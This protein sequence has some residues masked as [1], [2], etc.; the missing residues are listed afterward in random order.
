[1]SMTVAEW[2]AIGLAIFGVAVALATLA[3]NWLMWW[4]YSGTEARLHRV[5]AAQAA[6]LT[7]NEYRHVMERLAGLEG[8]L[9]VN[10]Q[11]MTTVQK[12][13]LENEK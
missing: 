11:L 4:R 1:M 13:L 10:I 9:N 5:E 12:H 2:W 8:Q 6:A 3:G 7:H